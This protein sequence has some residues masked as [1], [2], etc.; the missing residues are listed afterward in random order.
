[1]NNSDVIKIV[2]ISGSVRT[3]SYITWEYCVPLVKCCQ[4]AQPS[5]IKGDR[6]VSYRR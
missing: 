6:S 5:K 1:M 2:G 4:T 3:G